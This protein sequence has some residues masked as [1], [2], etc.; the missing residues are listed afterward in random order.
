[1]IGENIEVNQ[2]QT[3][4]TTVILMAKPLFH[5]M[6]LF[7]RFPMNN[8]NNIGPYSTS[9]SYLVGCQTLLLS[10]WWRHSRVRSGQQT[11]C[12]DHKHH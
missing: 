12:T 10:G 4:F 6:V 7:V 2:A 3:Q 8:C 1:M 5:K 11:V 9:V